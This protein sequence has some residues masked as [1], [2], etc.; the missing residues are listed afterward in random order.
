ML[1]VIYNFLWYN[2]MLTLYV[3]SYLL[4]RGVEELKEMIS[5]KEWWKDSSSKFDK[6][7]ES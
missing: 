4:Q 6:E 2:F 1:K 5:L 7:V 3:V